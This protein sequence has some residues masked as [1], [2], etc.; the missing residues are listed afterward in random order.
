[1]ADVRIA[2]TGA[3]GLIGTG[4]VASLNATGHQ[5]TRLVRRRAETADEV[6]WDPE[7]GSVGPGLEGVDAAIHLAGAGVG[8]HRWTK[9]YK[10]QIRDSRVLGTGTL[11]RA[12]AGL[13]RK[14]TVLISGSAIGYYGECG[15]TEP[16]TETSPRGHGFLPE[17]VADWEAAAV[18]AVEA[19]I[20][21]VQ[22][23]SGL[24]V[25]SGGGAFARLLPV[26]RF[27]IGGQLGGGHQY[28]SFISLRDEIRALEFLLSEPSLSGPVNLVAPRAVTNREVTKA[29]AA[30]VHRPAFLPVPAWI[31][32]VALGEFAVE[33]LGSKN[34]RPQRL[35][36][37]GFTWLD[38]TI[39]AALSETR[40]ADRRRRTRR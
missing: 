3:S 35:E 24:V 9:A 17:V 23:R 18:P 10:K 7:G 25:G 26:F 1:M 31:L 36:R 14:P 37:A 27:G 11:S 40:V 39:A 5:V 33:I 16:V 22:A 38:P 30:F 21:V 29:I 28:W 19:G 2:V 20:R 6:T 34:V 8:D 4:L 12:L 32:K 13:D 15:D